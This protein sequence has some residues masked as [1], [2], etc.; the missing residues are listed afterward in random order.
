MVAR[1]MAKSIGMDYA[2][3]SGGDVGPLGN[4]AV[5]QI[6]NLF[7]WARFSNKGV[8]LFID[9]AEC[10]LGDR[11]NISMSETAHNSLNA[12][13]YNT[14]TERTDFMMILATNRAEDLDP[15]V[16]D[17]C[18]ESLLF[19][20][21]DSA[22]RRK[23]LTDY[24]LEYVRPM[25]EGAKRCEPKNRIVATLQTLFLTQDPFQATIEDEV[26]NTEQ[27]NDIVAKTGGFSGREIS[28]LMIAVQ[29]AIFA[30]SDGILTPIMIEKIVSIKVKE[31]N[32]KVEMMTKPIVEEAAN[33]V[34]LT[35]TRAC[36]TESLANDLVFEE[37]DLSFESKSEDVETNANASNNL[38]DLS[39][40]SSEKEVDAPD[41]SRACRNQ[42]AKEES[43]ISNEVVVPTKSSAKLDNKIVEEET[44]LSEQG[45]LSTNC[46][47]EEET[48]SSDRPSQFSKQDFVSTNCTCDVM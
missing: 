37:T 43:I 7:R 1:K 29:G 48:R 39:C 16:L 2:L 5:T 28:K 40:S 13:L 18:D 8:L 36:K 17:R 12:L 14:G 4:D 44:Q 20:L 30:S 24:F 45:L 3:M 6:H 38:S 10:F 23:L 42:V 21:P 35:P 46:S 41:N 47:S 33:L 19:P 34:V 32:M 31:H 25:E 22:C 27:L 11:S 9:E 15:A 26:M